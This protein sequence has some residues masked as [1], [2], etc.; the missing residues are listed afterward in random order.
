M[1]RIMSQTM[2]RSMID[3]LLKPSRSHFSEGRIWGW[4]DP[5][6]SPE[7][8][9][10]PKDIILPVQTHSC[11]IREVDAAGKPIDGEGL[12]DTDA[13][14]TRQKG[15]VI[16][17]RTADCVPILLFAPD[18]MAVAAIHAGWKGTLG[19]IAGLTVERLVAMG[20]IRLKST[21]LSQTVYV[22]TVMRSVKN[23]PRSLSNI[24]HWLHV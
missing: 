16:G 1:S 18:I 24:L 23:S 22:R 17:V 4:I 12:E 2:S 6:N 11:N 21:H 20:A 14:I 13:L 10:S 3:D 19:R 7:E 8:G 15:I 9:P 5:L